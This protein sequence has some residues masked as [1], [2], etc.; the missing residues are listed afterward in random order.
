MFYPRSEAALRKT[1]RDLL[2]GR[3]ERPA[4]G[5]LIALIVPHAGYQFSGAT[6]AH[7]Y[8]LLSEH[9]FDTAVIVS[10]SHRI[11]F[12]HVSVYEG[13]AYETPLGSMPVDAKL[14]E[15][16]LKQDALIIASDLGHHDEHAIEVQLPFLQIVNACK[17]ILPVV[18]GDQRGEDCAALGRALG[19][20]LRGKNCL[21]IASTDLSHYHRYE[22]AQAL[23]EI[24]AASI[25]NF[26][27]SLLMRDLESEQTEAC[28]GGPTVAVLL[29]AKMLGG[30]SVRVLHQ[31]NSGDVTSDRSSVVGYLSAA[32][33]GE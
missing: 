27:P 24:A 17:S 1:L 13:D 8:R 15:E 23:D 30:K 18:M 14:R 32:V 10:P 7:A 20:A 25:R 5:K 29:A 11:Y 16:L 28:G 31:C 19:K 12:E 4:A 26:E 6:A 21:L 33:Y 22:R 2:D 3:E 9:S